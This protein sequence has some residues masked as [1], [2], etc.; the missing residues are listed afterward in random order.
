MNVRANISAEWEET[1]REINCDEPTDEFILSLEANGH[2][3]PEQ[4]VIECD[5]I[6]LQVNQ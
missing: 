1:L 3:A 6:W 2:D 5:V 4:V